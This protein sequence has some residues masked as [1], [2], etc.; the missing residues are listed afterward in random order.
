MIK[1]DIIAPGV[2]VLGP[3]P[4]GGFTSYTGT[5]AAAAVTASAC[6]LLLQWATIEGKYPYMNTPIARGIL[7]R[8]ARRQREVT[9][10]NNIEGYGRLDLQNS[11]NTL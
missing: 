3:T 7:T 10:P 9:Y 6:A 4:G 11:L 2:N 1:P 5:S 8:G